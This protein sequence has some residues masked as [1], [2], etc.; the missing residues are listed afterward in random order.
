MN[1]LLTIAGIDNYYISGEASSGS[2]TDG[3]AWNQV[4]IDGDWYHVDA[5][6]M[7]EVIMESAMN[8]SM[9]LTQ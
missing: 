2:N 5:T 9:F 6:W 8:F 1:L 3:H 4:C 7:I